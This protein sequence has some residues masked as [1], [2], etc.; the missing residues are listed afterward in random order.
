MDKLFDVVEVVTDG[1]LRHIVFLKM[2]LILFE[3]L[4]KSNLRSP[5]KT[6]FQFFQRVAGN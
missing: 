4:F 2:V 3:K 5:A 1:I 6:K